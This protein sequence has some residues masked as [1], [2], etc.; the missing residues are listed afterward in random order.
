M[1]EYG[2]NYHAQD[3]YERVNRGFA[4]D[5][6]FTASLGGLPDQFNTASVTQSSTAQPRTNSARGI[7]VLGNNLPPEGAPLTGIVVKGEAITN[8]NPYQINV[9]F[10][11]ADG[12][13]IGEPRATTVSSTTIAAWSVGAEDDDWGLETEDI[14]D[15]VL[16]EVWCSHLGSPYTATVYRGILATFHAEGFTPGSL[17]LSSKT[18]SSLTVA[19]TDATGDTGPYL[20]QLQIAPAGSGEWADV[21]GATSSPHTIS[22]L[23]PATAYDL[24]VLF[25]DANDLTLPSATLTARTMRDLPINPGAVHNRDA[26]RRLWKLMQTRRVTLVIVG[27]S[28][29]RSLITS[30]HESGMAKGLMPHFAHWG[31]RPGPGYAT[32]GG[33]ATINGQQDTFGLQRQEGAPAWLAGKMFPTGTGFISGHAYTADASSIVYTANASHIVPSAVRFDFTRQLRVHYCYATFEEG[34]GFMKPRVRMEFSPHTVLASKGDVATAPIEDGLVWDYME[35]PAGS[36]AP[37]NYFC[38]LTDI[39]SGI[40]SEGPIGVTYWQVEV[41]G[42]RTGVVYGSLWA[43]GGQGAELFAKE[44]VNNTTAEAWEHFFEAATRLQSENKADRVLCIHIINGPNDT[45]DTTKAIDADGNATGP[46]SGTAAGHRMNVETALDHIAAQWEAAGYNPAN[47]YF[48]LGPYHPKR[49]G[50]I[51]GQWMTETAFPVWAALAEERENVIAID[52]DAMLTADDMDDRGWYASGADDAHLSVAGYEGFGAHTWDT[53]A[54]AAAG[55]GDYVPG[56]SLA[57]R[58]LMMGDE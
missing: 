54:A 35:V 14:R 10:T 22:G 51:T 39:S 32:G 33:A 21:P 31:G 52:G 40:N 12:N 15:G 11:D 20:A 9:Q 24:R 23:P 47:L 55:A 56:R 58:L 27:D 5:W 46:E 48:I 38:G 34:D 13:L 25:T 43:V 57:H 17:S 37:G 8:G 6:I 44:V 3:Q 2:P 28:N 53:F 18:T 36:R 26:A 4:A 41:V 16:I 30:G 1:A 49:A 50:T 45:G 42:Q 29:V 19:W 7:G